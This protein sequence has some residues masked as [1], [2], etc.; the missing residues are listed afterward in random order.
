MTSEVEV[1]VSVAG[2]G[3]PRALSFRNLLR[4]QRAKPR[5]RVARRV[6]YCRRIAGCVLCHERR[7]NSTTAYNCIGA[8][9][10]NKVLTIPKHLRCSTRTTNNKR[11][12]RS[13]LTEILTYECAYITVVSCQV[14]RVYSQVKKIVADCR[15]SATQMSQQIPDRRRPTTGSWWLK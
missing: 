14:T 4:V 10:I 1:I 15:Y 12:D 11:K 13:R 6:T 9:M 7:H 5:A 3:A 8:L 2:G